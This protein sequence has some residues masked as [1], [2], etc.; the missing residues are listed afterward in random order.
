MPMLIIVSLVTTPYSWT[1]DLILLLPVIIYVATEM[2]AKAHPRKLNIVLLLII[3][4]YMILNILNIL[5]HT[6]FNE[7]WFGWFAPGIFLLF[8]FYKTKIRLHT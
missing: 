4:L 8:I 7:F 2:A 5:L 6:Q 1:Y 3:M